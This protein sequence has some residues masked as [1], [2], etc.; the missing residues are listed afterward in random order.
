MP[1]TMFFILFFVNAI[2]FIFYG[3]FVYLL[4]CY[5]CCCM[6]GA[7]LCYDSGVVYCIVICYV[8][9]WL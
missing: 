9:W 7:M 2:A 3:I 6:I 8:Y 1:A 4:I 5:A